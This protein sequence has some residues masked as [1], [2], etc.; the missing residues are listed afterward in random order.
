MPTYTILG[1]T[2]QVGGSVLE[3]LLQSEQNQINAY[4]RSKSKLLDQKPQLANDP[5]IHIFEGSLDDIA[6]LANCCRGVRA[7]FMTVAAQNNRP[8]CSIAQDQARQVIATMQALREE[9]E[10]STSSAA[11]RL[12][13]LIML[14]SATTEPHLCR[15]MPSF[16]RT[17]LHLA[18]SNVYAD[19]EAAE[20]MLRAESG[21]LDVVY[22]KP[23]AISHDVQGGHVL[24]TEE[25]ASPVS[26]LDVAAG[27]VECGEEGGGG[28]FVGM[29]VSV[30]PKAE[31]VKVPWE[32]PVSLV[33]GLLVHFF[34]WLYAWMY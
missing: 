28:R 25:Q 6:L 31:K 22:F 12:P 2:G 11:S 16:A 8:G 20:R 17:V 30:L 27:M 3:V 15:N 18:L 21:W 5:R 1:A 29:G 34:P 23:G 13:T 10:K 24:S 9:N 32:A 19:L 33:Q 7:V 14:S 26:Y 4:C